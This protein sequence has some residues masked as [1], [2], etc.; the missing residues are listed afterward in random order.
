MIKI[1]NINI[2]KLYLLS[3][4]SLLILSGKYGTASFYLPKEYYYQENDKCVKFLF[5]SK[6][7]YI[8]CLKHLAFIINSINI[9]YFTK[10]RLKGLGYKFKRFCSH[11]YRFYFTKT[12]FIYFHLPQNIIIK[13]RKKK[14]IMLSCNYQKLRM[15]FVLILMLKKTGPYNRRGFTYPRRMVFLKPG[16]TVN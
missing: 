7:N 5:N 16:K 4:Q 10:L 2:T 8:S 9:I 6:Y 14:I 13:A 1:Y 12:N 3:K 15:L 11:L